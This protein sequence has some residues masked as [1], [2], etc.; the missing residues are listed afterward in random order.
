MN[1]ILS[2]VTPLTRGIIWLHETELKPSSATFKN[3]DYLLNGLLTAG[4]KSAPQISSRVIMG[5]N[6][7]SPL[8]VYVA[9]KIVKEE[10][11]SFLK[12][13]K[14]D[15]G[16]E[17]TVL[18]IDEADAFNHLMEKTPKEMKSLLHLLK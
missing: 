16:I 18:V 5:T 9:S 10:F 12:L 15:I 11:E 4:L 14:K 2:K 6:F 1:D 13:L 7:H 17:S 8:H 3:V